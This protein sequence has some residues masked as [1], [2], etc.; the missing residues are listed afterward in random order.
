MSIDERNIQL[1]FFLINPTIRRRRPRSN[2][3]NVIN[4]DKLF[5]IVIG[6]RVSVK[7]IVF[8]LMVRIF[9][10]HQ[11]VRMEKITISIP[12]PDNILEISFIFSPCFLKD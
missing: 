9:V 12:N 5:P 8:P 6:L 7:T 1:I 10:M 3:I 11:G 4:I 2:G